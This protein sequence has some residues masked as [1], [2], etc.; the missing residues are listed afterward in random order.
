VARAGA[1]RGADV[2]G[3]ADEAGVEALRIVLRRQPHHGGG[4]AKA[5]HLVAAE[6][7]VECAGHGDLRAS[8]GVASIAGSVGQRRGEG[9]F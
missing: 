4:A 8:R 1:V 2:E 5:R 3:D 7:L 6:R 9:K